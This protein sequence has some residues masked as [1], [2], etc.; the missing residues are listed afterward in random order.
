MKGREWSATVPEGF[1]TS[2]TGHIHAEWWL[3]STAYCLLQSG[4]DAAAAGRDEQQQQYE[5]NERIVR[6]QAA[7]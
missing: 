4:N 7:P 6:G 5:A 3:G 1:E 2:S